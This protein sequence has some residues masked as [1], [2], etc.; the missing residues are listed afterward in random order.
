MKWTEETIETEIKTYVKKYETNR[1]PTASELRKNLRGDLVNA[2][3]KNGGFE[4]WAQRLKL[5]I[6]SS[7]T[8]LGESFEK[9]FRKSV[10]E[11]LGLNSQQMPIKFPYD[12]LIDGC[13]KVDV[14]CGFLYKG[15][16]GSFYTF[17]LEQ[18]NRKSDLLACYCLNDD[19]SVKKLY[20]IPSVLLQGHKQL[21]V[22]QHKS[23]YDKY[24]NAYYLILKY[25]KFYNEIRKAL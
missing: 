7:E 12:V 24:L 18:T 9:Y 13:I 16:A 1:M 8:S 21:S 2:I 4:N 20:V 3:A 6:K 5:N 19:K 10:K 14:K 11:I 23:I 17:N 22:G 25:L 15:K